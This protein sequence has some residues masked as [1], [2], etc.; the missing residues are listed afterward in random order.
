MLQYPNLHYSVLVMM[1][2]LCPLSPPSGNAAIPIMAE[3][4]EPHATKITHATKIRGCSTEL[5][6]LEYAFTE[7]I[8]KT[9][10]IPT[11]TDV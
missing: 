8:Q 7:S 10:T 3:A 4:R 1:N 2:K 5:P 9:H 6:A 11:R